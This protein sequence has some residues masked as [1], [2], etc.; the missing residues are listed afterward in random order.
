MPTLRG[1]KTNQWSLCSARIAEKVTLFDK[2]AG[3]QTTRVQHG[4]HRYD[5]LGPKGDKTT[6][7]ARLSG[8][9]IIAKEGVLRT[10][11]NGKMGLTQDLAKTSKGRTNDAQ[12]WA[13]VIP[14]DQVRASLPFP[15]QSAELALVFGKDIQVKVTVY[16]TDSDAQR[17]AD[18]FARQRSAF[19]EHPTLKQ[20]GLV[21]VL[22]TLKL[23]ANGSRLMA[24]LTLTMK[25]IGVI[26]AGLRQAPPVS[27]GTPKGTPKYAPAQVP[28]TLPAPSK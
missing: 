8:R 24:S 1:T 18:E 21:S 14:P 27:S 20:L 10:I 17:F 9:S 22:K 26:M 13:F 16:S 15:V 7:V 3:G 4:E 11:L 6:A 28:K 5:R 25:D 23:S 2:M 12:L 19:E